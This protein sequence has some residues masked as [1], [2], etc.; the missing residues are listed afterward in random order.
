M[1]NSKKITKVEED[2]LQ[3]LGEVTEDLQRTRADFENYRKRTEAEKQSARSYGQAETA[4]KLLP[5]IDDIERAIAHQPAELVGNAWADG[6]ATLAKNLDKILSEIGITKIIATPGTPFNPD[7]HNAIHF[8]EESDG[9][10]EVIDEELQPGYV[11]DGQVL[12][13]AMVKVKR[14]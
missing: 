9:E 8:N 3:K 13:E 6:I 4:S 12:R 11:L 2:L 10:Q 5:I 7:I 14:Q 1:V